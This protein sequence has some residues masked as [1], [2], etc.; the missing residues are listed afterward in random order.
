MKFTINLPLTGVLLV[1]LFG[2][3]N[4]QQSAE[5]VTNESAPSTS[6][7]QTVSPSAPSATVFIISPTNGATVKSPVE[8]KFGI[9]GME[10]AAAGT[11]A[12]DTG[13]HHLLIDTE[14]ADSTLPVPS[15][16]VHLHFGKGQTETTVALEPGEHSLQ[17]VLGDGNHI[18]H[19]PPIVS[20]QITVIV[21]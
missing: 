10:V 20:N 15:D 18:P 17:L 9:S 3:S 11:Y 19:N 4:D 16:D 1:L 13:H 5:S 8:V 6:Q 2:C 12:D 21:E 14:M 7:K